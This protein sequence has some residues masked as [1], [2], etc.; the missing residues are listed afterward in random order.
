M[1]NLKE[2]FQRTVYLRKTAGDKNEYVRI[3]FTGNE[4]FDLSGNLDDDE[5]KVKLLEEI[6]REA[7]SVGSLEELEK[8]AAIE[9]S[10]VLFRVGNKTASPN[11]TYTPELKDFMEKLADASYDELGLKTI[12]ESPVKNPEMKIEEIPEE[13]LPNKF[14]VGK[15]VVHVPS[16]RYG[17]IISHASDLPLM[18]IIKF[19]DGRISVEDMR[20][21]ALVE[22][23]ERELGEIPKSPAKE[24]AEV[25]DEY[26][27]KPHQEVQNPILERIE[28]IKDSIR[29]V[30]SDPLVASKIVTR[31]MENGIIDIDIN[32]FLNDIKILSSKEKVRLASYLTENKLISQK[33]AR[34]LALYLLRNLS[35]R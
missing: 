32:D 27:P 13:E 35:N 16:R 23:F 34:Q 3:N 10:S 30:I 4:D 20:E 29:E 5:L 33:L 15:K 12:S 6:M 7:S 1:D 22:E 14:A 18:A 24:L 2:L 25:K 9:A 28:V 17:I 31:L 26:S 8:R 19:D 21:L 11:R